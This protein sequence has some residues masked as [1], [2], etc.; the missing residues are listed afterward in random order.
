MATNLSTPSRNTRQSTLRRRR[1]LAAVVTGAS[2]MLGSGF[3]GL[4]P[5]I[6]SGAIASTIVNGRAFLDLNADGV[7]VLSPTDPTINEP[8]LAGVTVTVTAANGSVSTASTNAIGDWSLDIVADGPYRVQYSNIPAK[9]SDGRGIGNGMQ[10][11][12]IA[13]GQ[14][15]LAAFGKVDNFGAITDILDGELTAIGN[16]IWDDINGNGIQDAGEP[17]IPNVVVTISST[18]GPLV[19]T[20]GCNGTNAPGVATSATTNSSGQYEFRCLESG[21]PFVLSIDKSQLGAGG[22][23][24][25]YGPTI[26]GAGNIQLDSNGTDNGSAIIAAGTTR[27]GVDNTYDFGFIKGGGGNTTTTTVVA[28]TGSIGNLVFLDANNNGTFDAGDSPVGGATV[29]LI[30]NGAVIRTAQTGADGLY[31]FVGLSAGTYAVRVTRP[32]G[33]QVTPAQA[34]V[35]DDTR[36]SDGIAVSD[37][38]SQSGA[39]TL[40]TGQN[41]DTVDFGWVQPAA[42]RAAIGDTVWLDTNGN[43]VQDAGDTPVQG[44]NVELLDAN[45]QVVRSFV[46]LADGK[47]SFIDLAPGTYSIRVTR[48]AGSDVTPAAANV[49]GDDATDSDGVPTG[50]TGQVQSGPYTLVAG[51]T[52]NTADF[53]WTPAPGTTTTTTTT[54]TTVLPGRAALGDTVFFDVNNNDVQDS[55]DTPV[56]GALVELRDTNG[57]LIASV[58]TDANGKYLFSNLNPGTYSVRVTRPAGSTVVPVTANV[59]GDDAND[60]DGVTNGVEG[61]QVSGLYTLVAG[62]T[63]LTVDFGWKTAPVVTTTTTTTTVAPGRAAIGDTVFFDANDN[64]VQDAGDTAVA[65]ALVEL[66]SSTGA[67]LD[68]QVTGVDGKYAFTSLAPGSYQVRVTRPVGST[69]VPVTPNVGD[70]AADSDGVGS[71]ATVVSGFY[72]LAAGQTNNTVDFGWKAA[73][74][75]TT[76]TTTVVT[77]LLASIGDTVWFDANGNNVLDATDT[78]IRGALIELLN[79]S[80]AVIATNVTDSNGTYGFANLNPGTYQVRVTRPV[81][82]TD[83]AVTPN[84]GADTAD[85]D[86]NPTGVAGQ[87]LSGFYALAAGQNNPTVDF[88]YKAAPN[89]ATTTTPA[90][91]TTTT[92]APVLVSI[93]DTVWFDV[94]GN[95]VLDAG[96][97][98]IRG[99]FVELLNASGVVVATDV[100]DVAGQYG[101]ASLAPG[102][103]QVRVTRPVG[104]TD[105]AVTPNVGADTADSDGNP[106][107]VAGQVV[108][109]FYRLVTGNN[110]TV[111]FGFKAAP[112]ATTTTTVA[113]GRAAIGDTVWLDANGNN[114]FDDNDSPVVG[115]RVELR[116]TNGAVVATTT[117]DANGKY[118]FTNLDPGVYSVRV[119]RPAGTSVVPV[120]PN[121]GGDDTNDSDG[122]TNGVDGQVVSGRYTLGA[123]QTNNTVDFGWKAAPAVTTT[124]VL[125]RASIGDTVFFDANGNN[126]QDAG[127]GPI[128]G[129][130]VQLLDATGAVV[131][132][133]VTDAEG[134]YG[135][136]NLAPGAY[137]VRVTRPVGSTDVAVT[138][139]AGGD[140]VDSDGNPTGVAG[141]VV[142]G[143]YRLA[144][145]DSNNTVD[146]GYKAAPIVTTTT[147]P[148]TTTTVLAP[149]LVSIG[150]TVWFDVNGNNVLDAGDTRIRG[151]FVELLNASGVVVATDVTDVAGQY[152]FASLAPGIYQVRVTRPVGST[153]VAVTP[154]VGADT[155]DSDGNP[156]GVAGQ[157][158]SGFYRLVTGNNPTVDF[159]FKAAPAATTTTTAAPARASI[160][161][162][163]FFDTNGN[164]LQDAGEPG[165]R[166]ALVQLLDVTGSVIRSQATLAD[167]KY[168]FGDL[169]AGTYQVRVTRP[170]GST[171]VAVAPNVGG[172]AN[173]AIDSDGNPTGTPGVVVSGLYELA[174]GQANTSVDFGFKTAPVDTTT[175]TA[176]P[177][178]AAIGDTVFFD[179]DGNNVFNTGDT[180]VRG[181]LVELLNTSGGV[182]DSVVTGADGKYSFTNLV[183]GNYQVRVTRPVGSTVVPVTPNTGADDTIDSDGNGTGATVVSG[184]IPLTAGQTNNTVDFGWKTAPTVPTVPATT[185][186]PA[187]T[188]A[189]AVTTTVAPAATTTT[190]QATLPPVT[191]VAAKVSLGDRL[192]IDANKNGIQDANETGISGAKV[193]VFRAD[194][195]AVREVT[196]GADGR[197]IVDGL[198]AGSYYAVYG[199]PTGFD[200]TTSKVGSDDGLD[201]D[202][203]SSG[204]TRTVTLTAGQK[205]DSLDAGVVAKNNGKAAFGDRLFIDANNNGKQDP[206]ESGI[207][208][209]T[210]TVFRADGTKVTDVTTGADGRWIVD[211]LEPGSY[212]AVYS[213]PSG[214]AFTT[215]AAAGVDDELNSDAD[216]TGRTQTITLKAGDDNRS[217][218]AGLVAVANAVTLTGKVFTGKAGDK[219]GPAVPNVSV[220]LTLPDGKTV[221]TTTD[222]NGKYLF[223]ALAPGEYTVKVALPSGAVV[224]HA[225]V[226]AALTDTA[227]VGVAKENVTDVNFGYEIPAP[228]PPKV[229][230]STEVKVDPAPGLTPSYTGSDTSNRGFQGAG[231]LLMGLGL[232]GLL[233]SRKEQFNN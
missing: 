183:P 145:G 45:G 218:D 169:A 187:T 32:A 152:G 127:D 109:G 148:V 1:S 205:I 181:A 66:L 212:Y 158:V 105:V 114:V 146:F 59:G 217:L 22:S 78:R 200:W 88:G 95:N 35:G 206:G 33:T 117:T 25:G 67:V 167:G 147:V 86:G 204:R 231:L 10:T 28:N 221:T 110:P 178:R 36:D 136:T 19:T 176:A 130:L 211:T 115:A 226:T 220:T 40:A 69:V 42:G 65:N 139:N 12:F 129:A 74:I 39:I 98:R 11:Q 61:Q 230:P 77:P 223:S 198:D 83:V 222:A 111:D 81:G 190:T 93:G 15:N 94:N 41:D 62:Q 189:P 135:F 227:K 162:T 70:D 43:N 154:N 91:T 21:K 199:L 87:V 126:V 128:R 170:V 120:T 175:T 73:P 122:V 171:D 76:T 179:V 219:D 184:F 46:T 124:T 23:L 191:P 80:G 20:A 209:A 108:S 116:D 48:P 84:V 64:N 202:V 225:P 34:N 233:R 47:Y 13:G 30:Q 207:S 185:V 174:A 224:I 149:V 131:A 90:T 213:L 16:R 164:N 177:G 50:V 157:V 7:Q 208:G 123:G 3:A 165:V 194:G 37:G 210:V 113:P 58:N 4:I 106:T 142:S 182:I 29:E 138:P 60:S 132:S 85:S 100:T 82:S 215:R 192:F 141:Q 188:I 54:T 52:N 180:L 8:G 133:D 53:G 193:T 229:L 172:A 134:K 161:D 121:A 173:D 49:G 166:G 75:N 151:A 159:G 186:A 143:F 140:A 68:T 112:A 18:S 163:V 168:N 137:Q 24:A 201:S 107:G 55:G 228:K 5:G 104:S 31:N 232:A 6:S 155:A 96:D 14:A 103:Y 195:T 27:P 99:A 102:I 26:A 38:V 160:G 119:T 197:W 57:S 144:A 97:T 56:A 72:Q 156:T 118:A 2:L 153:D 214:Y 71:G 17:G 9:L 125:G 44:A 89:V 203:D 216:A 101:F 196:T 79:A 150:D 63:N 92:S 51:Q